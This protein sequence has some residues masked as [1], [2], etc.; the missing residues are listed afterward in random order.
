MSW[1][2]G[3]ARRIAPAVVGIGAVVAGLGAGAQQRDSYV[4]AGLQWG[5][6]AKDARAQLARSGFKVTGQS[7]GKQREF[8]VDR[9]HAVYATHDRGSRVLAQGAVEGYGMSVELAF[10]KND[11]LNHVI[12]HSRF[13]DGTVKGGRSMIDMAE[14][15]VATYEK[16]YGPATKRG[17]DGW[18]DAAVWSEAK[19]GSQLAIHV[20]GINGFMFSP[21]YRT[22]MRIDFANSKFNNGALVGLKL[23][24]TGG[25]WFVGGLPTTAT[26]SP[27]ILGSE[28]KAAPTGDLSPDSY[29]GN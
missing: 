21:S 4:F 7:A 18:A 6:S 10:G 1:N 12:I 24:M 17:D 22:A 11:K 15:I 8:A 13:W 16:R 23:D 14:K 20:R 29:R 5:M 27:A 28:K 25:G 2:L 9:L 26:A 19:D 3:L